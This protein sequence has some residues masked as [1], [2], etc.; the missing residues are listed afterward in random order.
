MESPGKKPLFIR[1]FAA[2]TLLTSILSLALGA[3]VLLT[4]GASRAVQNTDLRVLDLSWTIF[5]R[6]E[7]LTMAAYLAA[8]TGDPK[9]EK[10]YR[11]DRPR[12]SEALDELAVLEMDKEDYGTAVKLRAMDKALSEVEDRVFS[13]VGSGYRQT[14]LDL[15]S[16]N[17]YEKLEEDFLALLNSR[18]DSLKSGMQAT[19]QRQERQATAV[20]IS[21]CV[22]LPLLLLSW[23]FVW[24][25]MRRYMKEQE[26]ADVALRSSEEKYREL[27]ESANSIIMRLDAEGRITFLNGFGREFFG[28]SE[29]E[30]YGRGMVGTILPD[31]DSTGRKMEEMVEA[32]FANPDKY[33]A[34]ENENMRKSG[35]RVWVAWSNKAILDDMGKPVGLLCLGNDITRRKRAE[36]ALSLNESRFE[37]LFKLSQMADRSINEVVGFAL[38]KQIELTRSDIG[39]IG[40]L[41][42]DETVL[43]LHA[44]S[45]KTSET[46]RIKKD[47]QHFAVRDAGLWAETVRTREPTVVN[48]YSV[49]HAG[50]KGYPEGHVS[51]SSFLSVPA[52]EGNKIVAVAAVANKPNGYDASD[53]RQLSL[54]LDGIWRLVQR[55]R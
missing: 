8:A 43:T 53:V 29:E 9:W 24:R 17:D 3:H 46:C 26:R 6:D 15:L 5:H 16:G 28:Y 11:A 39:F 49:P 38:E 44:W 36:E 27:V 54:F 25:T 34:N 51:M 41:N 14:A 2:A 37:A 12:I 7:V 31:V 13:L 32:L 10:E 23:F 1:F 50:K 47:V 48:D 22:T 42:E 19:L 18:M 52:F 30:I 55:Q 20:L 35:E 21:I 40:F 33:I 4:Y 45:E